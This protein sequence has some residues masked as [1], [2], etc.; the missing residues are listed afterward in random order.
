MT[1]NTIWTN[2]ASQPSMHPTWP[3]CISEAAQPG[4]TTW[5][6]GVLGYQSF[7]SSFY[8]LIFLGMFFWT[9][10][11]ARGDSVKA[12]WTGDLQAHEQSVEIVNPL[13]KRLH[14][15]VKGP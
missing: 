3:A 9:N 13:L 1:K 6:G 8:V 11:L 15:M 7:F 5:K 14:T 2:L 4:S 10:L 12:D